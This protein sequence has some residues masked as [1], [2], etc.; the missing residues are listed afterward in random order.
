MATPRSRFDY[1]RLL[2]FIGP[3][4]LFA[5]W[6]LVV[7]AK[8]VS[9][10][11]LPTPGATLIALVTGIFGGAL[12]M[13]FMYKQIHRHPHPGS[14]CDRRDHRRP[15][16]SAP[17]QQREGVSQRRIPD[18]LLP[19]DP[20]VRAYPA[21]PADL[22]RDRHQQGCHRRFRGGAGDPVQQRVW[23][24]ERTQAAGD[25]SEWSWAHRAGRSS[26]TCCSGR[27]CSRR[28]SVCAAACRWRW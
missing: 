17:R 11:L 5:V 18:R 21:V 9:P 10:I 7:M 23:R 22:R 27:V 1:S 8:L 14:L 6:Q 15:A 26:A 13:D 12:A 24:D 19:F 28:S 4:A 25:G 16:G 20:I 3:L 2:P